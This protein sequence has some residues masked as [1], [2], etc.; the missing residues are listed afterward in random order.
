[1]LFPQSRGWVQ[2]VVAA[3]VEVFS[4]SLL[5]LYLVPLSLKK[6]KFPL[7]VSLSKPRR[8]KLVEKPGSVTCWM[9]E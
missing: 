3:V 5:F 8:R 4:T 9:L 7:S 1:L 6:K 2:A